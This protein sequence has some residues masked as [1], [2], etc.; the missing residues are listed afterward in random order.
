MKLF[1]PLLLINLLTSRPLYSQE[2]RCDQV[3]FEIFNTDLAHVERLFVSQN[4]FNTGRG[5]Y[6]YLLAF[7]SLNNEVNLFLDTIQSLKPGDHLID[8]GCG[9]CHF[10]ADLLNT[11]MPPNLTG[12][13]YKINY[14]HYLD[15]VEPLARELKLQLFEK[16]YFE[17]LSDEVLTARWGRADVI[18]DMMGILSYSS[19]I[20]ET[21]QRY[22]DL[23]N[24]G[25]SIFAYMSHTKISF[26]S[27]DT[28]DSW[29]NSI[30]GV[31]LIR[32]G[33]AIYLKKLNEKTV[34][35]KLIPVSYSM[36]TPPARRYRWEH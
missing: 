3:L 33:N 23:L 32:K 22:L 8:G 16:Q 2:R 26:A 20:S 27:N 4:D 14:G 25:G 24:V 35:P 36:M 28:L 12:I 31:L 7:M 1:I 30:T 9:N 17:N 13:S 19:N 6:D 18:T 5:R 21:I 29:L 10:L 11:P 34:V 15:H